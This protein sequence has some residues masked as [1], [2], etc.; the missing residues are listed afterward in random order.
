MGE[1]VGGQEDGVLCCGEWVGVHLGVIS[2][3]LSVCPAVRPPA[4]ICLP[5]T[6]MKANL[7]LY[8]LVAQT[9]IHGCRPAL[10][11]ASTG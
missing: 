4:S 10:G 1:K 11:T 2:V 5:K 6:D 3:F 8:A 9:N 7:H